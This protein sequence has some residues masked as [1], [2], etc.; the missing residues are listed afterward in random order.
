MT[1]QEAR[2]IVANDGF[3]VFF[4]F[5]GFMLRKFDK[6]GQKEIYEV[7]KEQLVEMAEYIQKEV[8]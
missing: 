6:Y 1:I 8:K 2:E 7:T 5:D 4:D 3:D